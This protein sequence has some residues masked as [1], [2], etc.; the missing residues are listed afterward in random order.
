MGLDIKTELCFDPYIMYYYA[1]KEI[2][3]KDDKDNIKR[4]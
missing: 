2:R 3:K 4:Q 1:G